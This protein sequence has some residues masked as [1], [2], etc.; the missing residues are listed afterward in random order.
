MLIKGMLDIYFPISC[1][2]FLVLFISTARGKHST[3]TNNVLG[4]PAILGVLSLVAEGL[5]IVSVTFM[6]ITEYVADQ[7]F[8]QPVLYPHF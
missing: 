4:G 1:V 6:T 8:H 5:S 2:Y 7:P 3:L